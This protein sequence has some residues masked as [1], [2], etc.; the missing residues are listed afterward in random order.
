[1]KRQLAGYPGANRR[2]RLGFLIASAGCFALALALLWGARSKPVPAEPGAEEAS[3]EVTA[4]TTPAQVG[5]LHGA[6]RA[7]SSQVAELQNQYKWPAPTRLAGADPTVPVAP[8]PLPGF[9]GKETFD[10]Q[11]QAARVA[12]VVRN[13]I[14]QEQAAAPGSSLLPAQSPGG[15]GFVQPGPLGGLLNAVMPPTTAGGAGSSGSGSQFAG[16]QN[17]GTQGSP[18]QSGSATAGSGNTAA[19]PGST[20]TGT[21]PGAVDQGSAPPATQPVTRRG[22]TASRDTAR[23]SWSAWT[24]TTSPSWGWPWGA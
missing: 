2:P 18:T 10:Y 8:A 15:G 12:E 21:S 4:P 24:A 9:E 14:A 3:A 20:V 11:A 5:A 22:R 1:M 23:P 17:P 16:T 7:A 6:R 13:A 19:A